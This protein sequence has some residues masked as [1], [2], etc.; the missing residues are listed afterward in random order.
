MIAR[1]RVEGIKWLRRSMSGIGGIL[2]YIFA[3]SYNNIP[4]FVSAKTD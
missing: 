1:G 2:L 3:S 4:R